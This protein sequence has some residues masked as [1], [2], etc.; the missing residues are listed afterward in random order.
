M[1]TSGVLSPRR[2]EK[3]RQ[4]GQDIMGNST[5]FKSAGL[6]AHKQFTRNQNKPIAA[7]HNIT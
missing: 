7:A 6:D 3:I 1:A 5:G 4:N 2:L